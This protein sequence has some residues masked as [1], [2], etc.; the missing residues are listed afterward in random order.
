MNNKP[1]PDDRRDNVEKIQQNI[2]NTIRNYRE[3]EDLI[4]KVDSQKEKND[5]I[6]KN[7][8]REQSINGK[9]EEIRD[10]DIAREKGYK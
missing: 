9:R 3:T 4:N 2:T 5:L 6:E 10:E 8:R 7:K 1:K